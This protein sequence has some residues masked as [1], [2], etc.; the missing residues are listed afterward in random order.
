[1]IDV[2]N[3]IN[4]I[5]TI[6]SKPLCTWGEFLTFLSTELQYFKQKGGITVNPP[7][8]VLPDGVT[9]TTHISQSEMTQFVTNTLNVWLASI[10]SAE[11]VDDLSSLLYPNIFELGYEYDTY[12]SKVSCHKSRG[13][14]TEYNVT[15]YENVANM[16]G[17]GLGNGTIPTVH[18]SVAMNS[19]PLWYYTKNN[20]RYPTY[21]HGVYTMP[22]AMHP[23]V[24]Y[25]IRASQENCRFDM[26]FLDEPL[27][28]DFSNFN[29]IFENNYHQ[30][31]VLRNTNFS[32]FTDD[33]SKV[34]TELSIVWDALASG[35][36]YA[37]YVN[38]KIALFSLHFRADEGSTPLY[39]SYIPM[40]QIERETPWY[41]QTMGT[42][43]IGWEMGIEIP[44]AKIF[45]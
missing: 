42:Q 38:K 20:D 5:K 19:K 45:I 1:M 30:D 29:G 28:S 44:K 22:G 15:F 25:P 2:Q 7:T 3:L 6:T 8:V 37:A 43:Y 4:N 41:T 11:P 16:C 36:P 12:G 34:V 32:N 31:C 23:F 14:G 33:R 35:I 21:E 39:N 27:L 40:F 9:T 13:E 10:N 24:W 18:G 17:Y 26:M